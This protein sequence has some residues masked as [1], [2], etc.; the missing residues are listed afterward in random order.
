MSDMEPWQPEKAPHRFESICVSDTC[1]HCGL[2]EGATIHPVPDADYWRR[3]AQ[4]LGVECFT[5]KQTA[6]GETA[7]RIQYQDTV[8]AICLE[9]DK[10]L[11]NSP[12]RGQVTGSSKD[13]VIAALRRVTSKA[14]PGIGAGFNMKNTKSLDLPS[15]LA[16][17]RAA[18]EPDTFTLTI[19]LGN[20]AMRTLGQAKRAI[21]E[22]LA[23]YIKHEVGAHSH[24]EVGDSG[25]IMDVNGNSVGSW[26]VK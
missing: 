26:E 15:T 23:R 4:G 2:P 13:E 16:S 20:D 19:E 18:S 6:S 24:A 21:E 7:L 3:V 9:L 14:L 17:R 22:S 12:S 5:L 11:G 8:Y 1:V 10:T 25:K